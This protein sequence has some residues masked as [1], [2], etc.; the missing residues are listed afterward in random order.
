MYGRNPNTGP[1]NHPSNHLTFA[2]KCLGIKFDTGNKIKYYLQIK[3]NYHSFQFFVDGASVLAYL[4]NH[5]H[6][7]C[8]W[9]GG[10]QAAVWPK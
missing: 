2:I 10:G 5:K 8:N 6:E 1:T 7:L 3:G 9:A 4:L